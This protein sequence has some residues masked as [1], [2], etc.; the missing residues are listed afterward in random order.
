MAAKKNAPLFVTAAMVAAKRADGAVADL[1]TGS[2][3]PDGLADG[4]TK[5][6]SDLDMI[7]SAPGVPVAALAPAVAA[8]PAPVRKTAQPAKATPSKAAPEASAGG[9]AGNED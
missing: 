4:E 3:V 6:L 1:Y 5:R 2:R 9:A 7:G 8:R